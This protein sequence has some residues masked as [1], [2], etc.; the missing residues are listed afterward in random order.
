MVGV[1]A[2][3]KTPKVAD[4]PYFKDPGFYSNEPV[5]TTYKQYPLEYNDAIDSYPMSERSGNY[6]HY[7]EEIVTQQL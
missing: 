3:A 6:S 5:M 2:M 1:V 4:P 7:R